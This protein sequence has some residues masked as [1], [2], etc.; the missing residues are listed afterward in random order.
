LNDNITF[1][2]SLDT[3]RT[4]EERAVFP[5]VLLLPLFTPLAQVTRQWPMSTQALPPRH[6]DEKSQ[7]SHAL[8]ATPQ[9][10]LPCAMTR[11][12]ATSPPLPINTWGGG[13]EEG[14]LGRGGR[15]A[16]CGNQKKRETRGG[17]TFKKRTWRRKK[18]RREEQIW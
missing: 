15:Q 10:T 17:K 14:G 7:G 12:R 18:Q 16:S 3:Q 4:G 1:L 8:R 6:N 5:C 11:V 13:A 9:L 2:L